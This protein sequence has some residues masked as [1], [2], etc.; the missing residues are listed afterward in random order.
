MF[1]SA[2]QFVCVC[3]VV[4][5]AMSC[6]PSPG[7]LSVSPADGDIAKRKKIEQMYAGYRSSFPNIGEI[8]A[9]ELAPLLAEGKVIVVDV[10]EP[11]EREVSVLTGSI[12]KEEF[13]S[14]L[15]SPGAKKVVV[16]CTIGYRSGEYVEELMSKGI[17]A[18]NLEGSILAWVHAG[19]QVVTPEGNET[20]RVHVY[21]EKWNLLPQG[22]EAVW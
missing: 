7:D 20:K 8:S 16:Y 15:G 17:V 5:S 2:R 18:F 12:T 9:E 4:L 1:A 19:Q 13:E 21:S 22:F 6:A 10:R 11:E 3:F 14:T